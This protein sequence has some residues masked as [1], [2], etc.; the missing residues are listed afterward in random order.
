MSAAELS[1]EHIRESEQFEIFSILCAA[2]AFL[3]RFVATSAGSRIPIRFLYFNGDFM[4]IETAQKRSVKRFSNAQ[5]RCQLWSLMRSTTIVSFVAGAC[6]G[7]E[8]G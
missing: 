8:H 3:K 6:G 7:E 2:E 4:A 5:A 1:N